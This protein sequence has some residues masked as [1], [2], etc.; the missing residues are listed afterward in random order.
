MAWIPMIRENKAEA[1][2]KEWYDNFRNHGEE[3][4]TS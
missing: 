2:L 1:E 3:W 4:I